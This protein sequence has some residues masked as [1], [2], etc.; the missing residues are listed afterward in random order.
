M[1][2]IEDTD[3]SPSNSL[4]LL[5]VTIDDKLSFSNHITT[6]CK[7]A[8]Q[9]IGV[10]MKLKNLI[11]TMAKLQLYKAAILP[12]LIYC[13]LVWHFCRA[14]DTRTRTDSRI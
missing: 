13:H 9:R 6:T 12:H 3:I 5:G 10:I 11:S 2:K 4:K 7:I 8:S 14:S 1:I